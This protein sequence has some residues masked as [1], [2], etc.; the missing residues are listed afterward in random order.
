MI[1]FNYRL[2]LSLFVGLIAF[3]CGDDDD[4]EPVVNEEELI[5]DVTITLT[6]DSNSTDIVVYTW[7]D[8][9][10]DGGNAPT[11][12]DG[13][14]LNTNASYTGRIT[15][16]DNSDSTNPEDITT[17]ILAEDEEHQFFFRSNPSDLVTIGYNDQDS[18][19]NPL[20]QEI[21]LTTGAAATGTMTITLLHEPDKDAVGVSA[22]DPTNAG[23][24]TDVEVTFNLVVN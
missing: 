14:T 22:G 8:R 5:T 6:N 18:N 16:A 17:E 1:K 21:K 13:D 7:S 19:G 20:G 9:D 12:S 10:G 15:L 23:G 4:P 24:E 2:L 11:I 3:S